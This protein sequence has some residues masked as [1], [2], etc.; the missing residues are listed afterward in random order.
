[1]V[2]D[3]QSRMDFDYIPCT[4]ASESIDEDLLECTMEGCDC[5]GECTAGI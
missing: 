1:M 4:V 2:D 5:D 3:V